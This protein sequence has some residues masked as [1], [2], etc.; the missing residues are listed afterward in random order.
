MTPYKVL[1]FLLLLIFALTTISG[2]M[3][4]FI[5]IL[6]PIIS[7]MNYVDMAAAT[8]TGVFCILIGYLLALS[9]RS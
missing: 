4:V 1:L 3:Y 2:M 6:I 5:T 8:L 9:T 7:Q